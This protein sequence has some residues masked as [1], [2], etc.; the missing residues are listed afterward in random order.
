MKPIYPSGRHI[1]TSFTLP[2]DPPGR[3]RKYIKKGN[4]EEESIG[5]D[6]DARG[7]LGVKKGEKEGR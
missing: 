6:V 5:A 1:L 4:F 3:P 7:Y 2:A